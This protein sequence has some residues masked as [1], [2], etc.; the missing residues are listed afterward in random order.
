MRFFNLVEASGVL[1]LTCP[2]GDMAE[3]LDLSN[4]DLSWLPVFSPDSRDVLTES[5]YV[6]KAVMKEMWLEEA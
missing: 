2:R 6:G 3:S 5:V 4:F 1:P